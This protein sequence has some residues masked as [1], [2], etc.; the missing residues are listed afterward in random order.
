[1]KMMQEIGEWNQNIWIVSCLFSFSFFSIFYIKRYIL[2]VVFLS[3][4]VNQ[5]QNKTLWVKL[6]RFR[7]SVA[8]ILLLIGRLCV[9]RDVD[10]AAQPP[11]RYCTGS[12]NDVTSA[13]WQQSQ[14][15]WYLGDV[16]SIFIH[17]FCVVFVLFCV[18]YVNWSAPDMVKLE[19]F[20]VFD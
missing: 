12:P 16:L 13:K 2:D 4:S 15:S 7:T 20:V 19:Y 1:M 8:M 6:H 14:T 5:K 3:K 11:G 17:L 18:L 10:T 9:R